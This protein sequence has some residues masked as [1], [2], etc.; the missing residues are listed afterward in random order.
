MTLSLASLGW[1]D[2]F[3]AAYRLHDR[4][5]QE[6][7][8]VTTVDRGVYGLLTASG[9]ARASIGGGLLVAAA[10]DRQRLPWAGDWL[11]VRS[12]PD[13]RCTVEAV[14]PRRS[15]CA[16]GLDDLRLANVDLLAAVVPSHPNP[17]RTMVRQLLKVAAEAGIPAVV[18]VTKVDLVDCPPGR[19]V[20]GVPQFAVSARRGDGVER[21][22]GL[23]GPGR[24]LGLIGGSGSGKSTVVNALAGAIVMPTHTVRRV[25]WRIRAATRRQ[26][27]VP[28]P[29]GGA[30]IDTPGLAGEAAVPLAR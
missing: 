2:H 3:R 4:P 17:S 6:P 9:P 8:R 23:V 14:L 21:L 12:W 1:D 28:L 11:V 22:R 29:G 10:R 26:S 25:D 15:T 30:V 18:V 20:P 7:A 13:E 19:L 5:D 27:L 24:T 16:A